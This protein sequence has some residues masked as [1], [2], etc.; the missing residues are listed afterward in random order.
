MDPMKTSE[1]WQHLDLLRD[2]DFR[3]LSGAHKRFNRDD[4]LGYGSG[5]H[6]SEAK[7]MPEKDFVTGREMDAHLEAVNAKIDARFDKFEGVFTSE[8]SALRRENDRVLQDG[9][10]TRTTVI[11]T[12]VAALG[13]FI[14]FNLGYFALSDRHTSA[15]LDNAQ[16]KMESQVQQLDE[17]ARQIE[18]TQ[19]QILERVSEISNSL[20]Q[21]NR[22]PDNTTDRNSSQ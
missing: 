12:V 22:S 1:I 8:V 5:Q 15:Q 11:A 17:R 19:A 14:T 4:M 6:S 16:A 9:R 13:I 10:S 20:S 18:S 7:D 3:D 21:T 2:A